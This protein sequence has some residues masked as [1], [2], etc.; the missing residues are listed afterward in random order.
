MP[1][2]L[3][4]VRSNLGDSPAFQRASAFARRGNTPW[5][6]AALGVGF[7]LF[8]LMW[9]HTRKQFFTVEPVAK[10]EPGQEYTPLPAPTPGS[11]IT[12]LPVD[13]GAAT[14]T[15]KPRLLEPPKPPPVAKAP[16]PDTLA[17]TP[18]NAATTN[19]GVANAGAAIT[20]AIPVSQPPP[21]YPRNAMRDAREGRV[22]VKVEIDA[23]GNPT[24]T[25]IVESSGDPELD[26]AALRG[27]RRWHFKPAMSHGAPVASNATV[28]IEFKLSQ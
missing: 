11:S 25:S 19:H 14:S 24:D 18:A 13:D 21:E 6:L 28:P 7:V 23:E 20:P 9:G 15:G 10:S 26:R 4:K 1:D 8:L 17:G 2:F 3:Q 12:S 27:V 5:V 16:V 22:R